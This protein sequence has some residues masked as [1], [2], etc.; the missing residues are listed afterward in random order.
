VATIALLLG[1]QKEVVVQRGWY[2]ILDE[3]VIP[4]LTALTSIE[5]T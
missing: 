4:A 5:L 3:A 1:R 2:S